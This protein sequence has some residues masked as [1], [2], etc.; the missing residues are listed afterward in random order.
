MTQSD[1]MLGRARVSE[2][3]DLKAYYERLAA[4]E[5][6]A[7]WTVANEIEPWQPQ[8]RSVPVHWSYEK[9]RPLVLESLDLVTGDE[10]GRRVVMLV[11]PGRRDVSAAV[12]MLTRACRSWAP[13]SR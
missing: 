3:A 5:A 1:D 10:A 7:L 11:N 6:G 2:T 13:A 8:P 12:G 4:Y 9:L